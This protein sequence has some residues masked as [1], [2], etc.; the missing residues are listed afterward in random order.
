LSYYLL[1]KVV[2]VWYESVMF[3]WPFLR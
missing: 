3:R 1:R 2:Q